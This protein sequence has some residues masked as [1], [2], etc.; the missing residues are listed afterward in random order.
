LITSDYIILGAGASG[1]MLAN[2]MSQDAFFNDK[3]ILI[4]DKDKNK[5]NDRTWC[6]WEEGTG[7]WDHILHKS[8]SNI[9]FGSNTFSKTIAISPFNYKMIRSE[10]FYKSLWDS[11]SLKPNIKFVED[12]VN[13]FTEIENGVQVITKKARYFG[14][15]LF[16][17][18]PNPE[19]Y[20]SQKKYP[21]LQQHFLGWFVKTREDCFDDS[22]AT[23][24]D[25]KVEQNC[26]TRFMY[27]LPS[28]KRTALFEYTLFSK[29]LLQHVDYEDAIKDYLS[30][31]GIVN[32][33][34]IEKEKGSIPMTSFK[35]SKLNSK[36]ILNIGTA[37]GWTK[38][39]TGYTFKNASKKT[40]NLVLFLKKEKNLSKF[41]KKTKYWFY[42]LIF[43]D[44][45][46]NHNEDGASLFSS[47]FKKANTK[48]IFKFLDEES[49]LF[50]DLKIILS[51]P[52]KRFIQAFFKRLF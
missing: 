1:L 38:T 24:M 46:A 49:S 17:S 39:S 29:K 8:W 35:F 48:T 26:N 43:L 18:L 3:L 44:V 45:L 30:E 14:A 36:H 20:K 10:K 28:D 50:E 40:K 23:F 15:K 11:I 33:E 21:V 19:V 2:R 51:V 32:Y 7:E 52:P 13:S 47:M 34:I 37:G 31:K 16:N 6:Y 9:F 42:D 25:F 4:I 41:H 27:V 5:G 22:V 12:S